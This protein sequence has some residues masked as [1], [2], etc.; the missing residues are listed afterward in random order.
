MLIG[1]SG[2]ADD[3]FMLYALEKGLVKAPW[4]IKIMRRD[5]QTLNGLAMNGKIDVSSISFATYPFIARRY[6][7][8][9]CG[10]SF[11]YGYGPVV[12]SRKRLSTLEGKTVAVPGKYTTSSLLL[13][14]FATGF[15]PIEMRFDRIMVAVK[16][17]EVDAGILLHEGQ[18]LYRKEGLR[19]VIGLGDLWSDRTKLPLPLGAMA[20]K[21]DLDVERISGTIRESIRHSLSSPREAIACSK[22]FAK[23]LSIKD[24][25]RYV[26]MYV[27]EGT[28]KM[29]KEERKAV[30]KL[31]SLGQKKGIIPHT[32]VRI[33]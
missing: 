30:E 1:S 19:K 12:V 2:D 24:V 7:L 9:S 16:R 21:K 33:I 15:T 32:K 8:L 23:G 11:G 20:A 26:R 14:L 29:G 17:G 22:R 18:L 4:K 31:Y 27:N 5:I 13:D 25:R 28:V 10:S 6:D 3:V